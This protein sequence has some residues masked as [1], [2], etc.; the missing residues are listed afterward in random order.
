M[1]GALGVLF[2]PGVEEGAMAGG[3]GYK[4]DKID[5]QPQGGEEV[6]GDREEVQRAD[7]KRTKESL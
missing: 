1:S 3:R 6:V 2:E 4:V 7:R 5:S